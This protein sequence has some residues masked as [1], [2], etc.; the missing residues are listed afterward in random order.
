MRII[1]LNIY[2]NNFIGPTWL[3]A[4]GCWKSTKYV[5]LCLFIK[6]VQRQCTW[7]HIL[8]LISLTLSLPFSD[9]ICN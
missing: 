3:L 1:Y 4:V 8:N 6:P 2:V 5:V 9:P 7:T